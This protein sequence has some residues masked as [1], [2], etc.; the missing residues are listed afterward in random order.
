[1]S[2]APV[3]AVSIGLPPPRFQIQEVP[4]WLLEAGYDQGRH[5]P[6]DVETLQHTVSKI[7]ISRSQL[8]SAHDR[9][10]WSF[11]LSGKKCALPRVQTHYGEKFAASRLGPGLR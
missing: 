1:M 6:H 11:E 8:H 2:T 10:R 9:G 4:G 5:G 3:P 7:T